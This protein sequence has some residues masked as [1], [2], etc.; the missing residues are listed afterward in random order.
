MASTHSKERVI[1]GAR[2]RIVQYLSEI[3]S[4]LVGAV[5]GSL[6]TLKVVK[7]NNAIEG[8]SNINQS[9]AKAGRDI[10]GGNQTKS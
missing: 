4:F 1:C 8:N 2:E 5:G 3:L 10:V 7:N 6:I 9:N